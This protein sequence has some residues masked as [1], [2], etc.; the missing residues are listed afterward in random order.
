M[1]S[2]LDL[3]VDLG[4]IVLRS[5]LV[6][7]SG[8]VGSV[9]DFDAVGTLRAYGAAVAKSV[10]PEQW[11]GRA[12]PRMAPSGHGMLNGIGIQ[13]PGIDTWAATV[14]P[15][16]ADLG[17]PIWGSAVAETP[18]GFATV[19]RGLAN[20]G[21]MAIEIN[22]SCPN[23]ETGAMFALD[24]RASAEVV[25]A[26]RGA[27]SVPIGAK[28]SPNA[29]DIVAVAS[30]AVDAGADWLVL[31]NA[32]LGAGIDTATRRPLLSGMVGGYSGGPVKA[33]ALRCVWDVS[34]ALPGVPLIGCGGISSGVDVVEYLLAGAN[35]VA[36]G[37]AHFAEPRVGLRIQKELTRYCGKRGI[38]AVRD[39]IKGAIPWS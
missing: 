34:K 14:G 32:V 5:P 37:T 39:L 23:L 30:A 3:S 15:R 1:A 21:V 25:E 24:P 26:V 17:V 29:Q 20:A 36:I 35:A 10:S 4:P 38:P 7:A 13:N 31:T 28:L 22:L 2:M 11:D 19:A 12:I 8:T 27:S 9:Y 18:S 16:L 6:A 33:I